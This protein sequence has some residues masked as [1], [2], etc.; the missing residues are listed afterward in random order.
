MSVVR[1]KKMQVICTT[2]NVRCQIQYTYMIITMISSINIIINVERESS[3]KLSE[4][5]EGKVKFC[6]NVLSLTRRDFEGT[7]FAFC[8]LIMAL[9]YST[10]HSVSPFFFTFFCIVIFRR[11]H[12][13]APIN[14]M[15][16]VSC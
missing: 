5:D 7:K 3:K 11:P 16:Y 2:W 13:F 8:P 4:A 14:R 1:V 15:K 9:I 6:C 10:K 12:N